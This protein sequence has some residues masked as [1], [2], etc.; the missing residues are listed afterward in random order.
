MIKYCSQ[1]AYRG[2]KEEKKLIICVIT[3]CCATCTLINMMFHRIRRVCIIGHTVI[4]WAYQFVGM[5]PVSMCYTGSPCGTLK[6]TLLTV[7]A[8]PNHSTNFILLLTHSTMPLAQCM[9]WNGI[10]SFMRTPG[11]VGITFLHGSSRVSFVAGG[12]GVAECFLLDPLPAAPIPAPPI[13][14]CFPRIPLPIPEPFLSFRISPTPS[15]WISH[16][17]SF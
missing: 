6:C 17:P 16:T 3:T 15:F 11:D 4:A 1:G 9:V 12:D 14:V 5:L 10:F 8:M 13:P 2:P 7:I